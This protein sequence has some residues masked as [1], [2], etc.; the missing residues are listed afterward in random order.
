MR[1]LLSVLSLS[2]VLALSSSVSAQLLGAQG[3]AIFGAERLFGIRAEAATYDLPAPADE[4]ELSATTI[5]F[6]L[7]EQLL[8]YNVPRLSFDYLVADKFS[9]GGALGFY[10]TSVEVNDDDTGTLTHFLLAPRAGFLHMF[11]SVAGIWPRAGL[12]FHSSSS[13]DSYTESGLA[14][15]LECM[16]PIVLA[17]HFGIELGLAFDRSLTANRDPENQVDYDVTYQSFGLQFALFGW[18]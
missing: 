5:S 2:G 13:E 6:G 17:P 3:D 14:L 15:N 18:I 11:G 4:Q 9:V 1:I 12:T 10:S 8:P 7:A 16:F